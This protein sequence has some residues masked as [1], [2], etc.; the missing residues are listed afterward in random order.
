MRDKGLVFEEMRRARRTF[1]VRGGV[2]WFDFAIA[3]AIL[4]LV[5]AVSLVR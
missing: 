4:L 3:L 1:G 2:R 5:A